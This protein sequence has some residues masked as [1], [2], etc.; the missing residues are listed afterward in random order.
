M[1]LVTPRIS[2]SDGELS[3]AAMSLPR[4][5]TVHVE[6]TAVLLMAGSGAACE[7]GRVDDRSEW[8]GSDLRVCGTNCA[9]NAERT[10]FM[11]HH[12]RLR[13]LALAYQ[14]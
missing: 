12:D 13:A 7:C 6:L 1:G 11:L 14:R 5:G 2:G 8:A 10:I 3:N 4:V 9:T